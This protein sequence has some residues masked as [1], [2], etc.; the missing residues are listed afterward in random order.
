MTLDSKARSKVLKYRWAIF[1]VLAFA[2]FFVYFHRVSTAVVS[3]DL[4]GT[5]GVGAASIALLSSA[6][7]YAYT[8]MQLPSGLLTDSWGP[9]KTVSIFT[10]VAA[11][12]AILTGIASSFLLVI[13]GRLLIGVGVAMVY[14]PIMKILATWYRKNEF[15]SLS[16]ILLAVGNIGALSAAGPLALMSGALGWQQVFLALGVITVV[17]AVAAWMI[18]RDRP[19]DMGLPSIQEIES[20][21][22]GE[23]IPPAK[24]VEKIPMTQAL[25]M[26][27]GSGMKFWPL[28]VWFFFMYGSIM[29]YQGLWAGPYY[30]DVLG[31][32]KATYGMVLTFIGIGMIIGCPLAGILSDKVLKSRRKVLI[33][34]TVAYTIIWAAIW[35]STGRLD[36]VI[37]QSALNFM[38]GFFGGFFVVSYAQIKELF[39][40]SIVGTTTA[41]LNIFPFA[42]GAILQQVTG[43]MLVERT[44]AGY[45]TIWLFMLVCMIIAT[46]A[47]FLSKEKARVPATVPT[48]EKQQE[49]RG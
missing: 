21:E 25:K 39:P 44:A 18:T 17:L 14:I 10:M 24:E 12:G 16:G 27:F 9:R 49:M 28:A 37:G 1:G 38:F 15:A 23:P 20:D 11:A 33:I 31:W 34:G 13:A 36:S 7:F 47:G 4:Q 42:G 6:Y 30:A 8:I 22:T 32:D 41:A 3:E 19:V 46:V 26:T 29:V 48:A 2:Y 40:I 35:M 45:E 5:F 43:L